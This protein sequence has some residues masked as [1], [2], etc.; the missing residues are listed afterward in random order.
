VRE[1]TAI[2]GEEGTTIQEVMTR[3]IIYGAS[4]AA[5]VAV[6]ILTLTS[7]IIP[8]WASHV[9][10][11]KAGPITYHYGLHKRCSSLTGSCE[12]F[13]TYSDCHGH[14]RYF[15]SMWRSIAFLMSFALVLEGAIITAFAAILMGGRVKRENGWK[16]LVGLVL[17]CAMTQCGAVA[18]V[19][20]LYDYDDRFFVGWKLD[21]SWVMTTVSWSIMLVIAGFVSIAGWVMPPEGGYELLK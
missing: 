9:E 18:L 13:P 3:K 7:I 8:R 6:S 12:R 5:F 11:T 4:L 2:S 20:Y 21:L 1:Q 16:V 10:V 14:D 15:C 17:I 19:A